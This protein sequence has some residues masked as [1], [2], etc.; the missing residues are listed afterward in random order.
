MGLLALLA[1]CATSEEGYLADGTRWG[2]A[3]SC[4]SGKGNMSECF[5]KADELCAP[6]S[7]D[8]THRGRTPQTYTRSLLIRC[9]ET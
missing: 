1:G 7:Y 9:R 5:Q 4:E 3:I 2:Y 8:I 6:K